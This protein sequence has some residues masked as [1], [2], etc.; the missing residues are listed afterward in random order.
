[1]T[2]AK[3]R[4]FIFLLSGQLVSTVGN[5]L[6][7]IALPWYVYALTGSKSALALTG[8][9]QTMPALI[10]LVAG[11]FV[12]RWPKRATMIWS[13]VIRALF[14]G[15]LVLDVLFHWPFWTVLAMVLALQAV[16]QFFNPA[17]G[18]LFPLLVDE[19]DVAA[20]S[21]IL[22]SSSATA[23]LLGT[24][25]GGA[26]MG[27]LGAPFLFFMDTISFLVS[28]FSLLFIRVK[29]V[30][31]RQTTTENQKPAGESSLAGVR[32]RSES[33][34][35]SRIRT[36]LKDWIEGLSLISRSKFLLLV[37]ASALVTNFA[38]APMDIT[39]TAWVKGPMHGSP[40]ALGIINGGFFVGVILGGMFLGVISKRVPLRATL[41]IGLIGIGLCTMAFGLF[42]TT[43]PET[44]VSVVAGVAAGSLN[45]ALS[46]TM[47][48]L[49][50]PAIRGRAF[51]IFGAMATF[52]T[53]LGM[54][55]FGSLMI[56]VSLQTLFVLIGSIAALSGLSF[57][58]P[59]PNDQDRLRDATS[60]GVTEQG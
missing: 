3:N 12:D 15:V 17:S 39:L 29:E 7:G 9:A 44:I 6:F 33:T 58:L 50:P 57:L 55:L 8:I 21:G 32:H 24:V 53:P 49:I 48:Q 11:V 42:H 38:L 56:H 19:G 22:Q 28:V 18:A 10:G 54:V 47:I 59:I 31:T 52:A 5:N 51:G 41:L 27:A 14:S 35:A 37:L 34:A 30:V 2:L 4:N 23:Q 36:F 16:G 20:G 13:D 25:S 60:P 45:G 1:M 46:A 26:L 40:L 43:V